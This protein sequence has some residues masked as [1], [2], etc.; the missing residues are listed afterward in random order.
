MS[1][2]NTQRILAAVAAALSL[3]LACGGGGG[4]TTTNPT[5]PEPG[6]NL[7]PVIQAILLNPATVPW[8]G[9]ATIDV[10]ASDT[11][12]RIA[13]VQYTATQGTVTPDAGNPL[14]ATYRHN[15]QGRPER[16]TVTVTDDR[17][18]TATS[19]ADLPVADQ[20]IAAPTVSVSVSPDTCHPRCTVTFTA[21]ARNA[22]TLTWS[23]CAEGRGETLRCEIDDVGNVSATCTARNTAGER[24]ATASARGTNAGPSVSGGRAIKGT[25]AELTG[26][27]SDP[28]GDVL[29]CTWWS[30]A[31]R[32]SCRKLGGCDDFSG[33][34]GSLPGCKAGF[35]DSDARGTCTA[36]ISCRDR[37]GGSS[38]TTWT[39]EP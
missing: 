32:G 7:S 9:T 10:T 16:L 22:D 33:R 6:V 36:S 37:F 2:M 34:G 8:G 28:D 15:G 17:Q 35:G 38:S 21:S 5:R 14:R 26:D 20:V 25:E 11:D 27:Y 12:G 23:G 4:G 24:S 29:N 30:P 3:G 18:A 13:S 19:G 1:L 39:I 31:S